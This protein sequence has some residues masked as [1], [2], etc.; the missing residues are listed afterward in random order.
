MQ[1]NMSGGGDVQIFSIM[2]KIGNYLLLLFEAAIQENCGDECRCVYVLI[3]LHHPAGAVFASFTPSSSSAMALSTLCRDWCM[4]Y[5]IYSRCVGFM[6][7]SID[8]LLP[9]DIEIDL[10]S[11]LGMMTLI[12]V[13]S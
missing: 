13:S 6:E 12:S 3:R 4:R 10:H 11:K 1:A 2:W 7:V 9:T 8:G 5:A